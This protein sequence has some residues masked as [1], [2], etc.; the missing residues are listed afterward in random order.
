MKTRFTSKVIL[1]QETLEYRDA[2][3]LWY[4]TQEIQELQG[5]VLDAHTCAICKVVVEIMLHVVK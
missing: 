4:G 5:H 1:L 2:I 3:N